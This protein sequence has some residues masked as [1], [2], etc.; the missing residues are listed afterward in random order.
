MGRRTRAT[1]RR[2][3][4]MTAGL[5]AAFAGLEHGIGE[6]T[7]GDVDTHSPLIESWPH[8]GAF[9]VLGG[10]P[11]MTLFTNLRV[12]GTV[13]ALVSLALGWW[14]LR[15]DGTRRDGWLLLGISTLLLLVGGGFGPPLIGL[16]VGI[17][18]VLQAPSD[19][20]TP[21]K[22]SA[23]LAPRWRML[24]WITVA[25]YLALFPGLVLLSWVGPDLPWAT[26]VLPF[27]A[28]GALVLSLVAGSTRDRL[29]AAGPIVVSTQGPSHQPK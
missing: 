23:G 16:V 13:T 21:G 8:V 19:A 4:A 17:G 22:V 28:F 11:A 2:T 3:V 18:L 20:T 27:I 7:R 26:A 12:A 1:A 9:D 5:L 15:S 14:A 29:D 10:E 25:A 6:L 24:L